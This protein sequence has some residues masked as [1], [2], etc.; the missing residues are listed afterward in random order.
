MA[1]SREIAEYLVKNK[2]REVIF[3]L[4]AVDAADYARMMQVKPALFDKVITA[5][6]T[7][8]EVRG[9]SIYPSIVTQFL[10][11]RRNHVGHQRRPI[12]RAPRISGF[13]LPPGNDYCHAR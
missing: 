10:L 11:D 2:A 4:N 7:L 13:D 6:K 12:G 5:I 3:S 9:D 1:L 8:V